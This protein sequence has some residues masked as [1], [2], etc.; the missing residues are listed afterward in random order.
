MENEIRRLLPEDWDGVKAIYQKGIATG[1]ATFETCCPSWEEW[2]VSHMKE[3]RYVGIR[4]GRIAGW[5]ALT[6][7]SDRCVYA[8]VAE[9]S[10]YVDPLEQKSGV[11]TELLRAVIREAGNQG[12]WTLQA[13][14]MQ[15]NSA[16]IA[17]HKKCGFREVGY[18]ERIGRDKD[19]VWRN[20]VLFER[21]EAGD[22]FDR[23][24]QEG[25]TII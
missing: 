22:S 19:G 15:G 9:I 25:I 11:G 17:L 13:G 3:C 10:V 24:C 5:I 20:T 23:R 1:I 16:S 8:G 7:V 18:R 21:R 12:I 6:P 2:N 14:I 4:H